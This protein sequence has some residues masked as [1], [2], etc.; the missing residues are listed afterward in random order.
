[1]SLPT[2]PDSRGRFGDYGGRFAPETLMPALIEL[3]AEFA[4]AWADGGFVAEYRRLLANFVGRPTPIFLAERLGR[5]LGLQLLL[6]REDLAHTGAHKINNTSA[7]RCSPEEWGK[8]A[9]LPRPVPVST[10]S[11]PPP[12]ARCWA[13]SVWFTWAARTLRARP[14]MSIAWSS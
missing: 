8:L 2:L 7:R 3:E 11:P 14:S 6:K 12:R 1:M 4:A 5:Q 10:A 9:S 13:S